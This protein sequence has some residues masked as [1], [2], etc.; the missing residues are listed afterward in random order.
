[1]SGCGSKPAVSSS[2]LPDA[3]VLGEELDEETLREILEA[4]LLDSAPVD[5][6]EK[7]GIKACFASSHSSHATQEE[8]DLAAK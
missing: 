4:C 8:L 6:N 3:Q 2:I 5:D 1:V 7:K